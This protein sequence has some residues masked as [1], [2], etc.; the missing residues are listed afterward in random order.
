MSAKLAAVL[1]RE[2]W[3]S[4]ADRKLLG[5]FLF[6]GATNVVLSVPVLLASLNGAPASMLSRSP[7][8]PVRC[9]TRH[10]CIR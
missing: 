9:S 10:G 4:A 3:G 5:F 7:P 2:G 8:S 6:Q 1:M